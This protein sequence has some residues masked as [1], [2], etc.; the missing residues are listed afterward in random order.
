MPVGLLEHLQRRVA[1]ETLCNRGSSSG[2]DQV[3]L[4]TAGVG[5][6]VGGEPCQWALTRKKTLSGGGALEVGD[7]R[8]LEDGSERGGARV[9]DAV[10]PDTVRDGWGHSE[11][12]CGG[13]RVLTERRTLGSSAGR[14]TPAIAAS[15]CRAAP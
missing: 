14:P 3:G 8:L 12:A 1:L 9:S 2:T 10:V 5:S 6:E 7:L 13:Q 11:R 4:E 15:S